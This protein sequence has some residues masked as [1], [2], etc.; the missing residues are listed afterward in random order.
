VSEDVEGQPASVPD[1]VEIADFWEWD[2]LARA[3]GWTDGLPV[4]PPTVDRVEAIIEYLGMDPQE[5]L[6]RLGPGN[7]AA[8][9]EQI[10]IQCTMAGCRAD[11]VPVVIAAVKA[12]LEPAF[13]I[14]GVQ[15]T[16]NSCAPLAVVCGPIVREL[17]FNTG[18]GVFGGGGW[19]NAAIGRAIRLV[20]WNIGAG[21]PGKSD[22][23]PLGQPAKF[24]FCIGEGLAGIPWT[25]LATD[26]GYG[27]E[28]N[29][30]VVFACQSPYPLAV[31]GDADRM[32][33]ILA[34]S[35]PSTGLM[36]FHAAG[37][38]MLTITPR[39]A[40]TMASAG[41]SREDVRQYLFDHARYNL[42]DLRRRGLL[43]APD[44]PE[45]PVCNYWGSEVL[46]GVR[47]N[48]RDLPDDTWLAMCEDLK[49][50][51][52][53]V[54]GGQ[55]QFF[56]GLSPGWGGYGGYATAKPIVVPTRS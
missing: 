3:R 5:S 35:V 26:F 54:S 49:D 17:D 21:V 25:S 11:H 45:D 30:V 46:D 18:D 9:I 2:A 47:P 12:M 29:C 27:S 23:S 8:T 44:Q 13:N 16:T 43:D 24:A 1:V 50:F 28:E 20:L 41:I 56:A 55:G 4:A 33:R 36:Q 48:T 32:L 6:G 15:A 51:H 31:V 10:A 40:D 53:L 37:Q 38:L 7:G 52:V 39:V 34:E 42:G 22:K 14:G 19:A